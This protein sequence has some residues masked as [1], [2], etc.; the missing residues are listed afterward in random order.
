M[1]DSYTWLNRRKIRPAY[2]A[3]GARTYTSERV[4]RPDAARGKRVTDVKRVRRPYTDE[5]GNRR[6]TTGRVVVTDAARK[7]RANGH[8]ETAVQL[9]LSVPTTYERVKKMIP[10][11]KILVPAMA[12][13]AV[14]GGI[15]GVIYAL[16]KKKRNKKQ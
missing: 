14:A 12:G 5:Y 8:G 7:A 9:E 16:R 6:Y 11:K 1:N 3:T 13:I 2:S 4:V 10:T 15:A